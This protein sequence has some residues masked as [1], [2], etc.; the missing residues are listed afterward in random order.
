MQK[1]VCFCEHSFE[2]DIP[3]EYNLETDKNVYLSILNGDFMNIKCPMC[4][5]ILKP[6]FPFKI[7]DK[8]KN[9]DFFFIPENDRTSFLINKLPYEINKPSRIVI[10]YKELVEKLLLFQNDLNDQA[11]E[12]IK[13]YLLIKLNETF[14]S[15]DI[16]I[17]FQKIENDSLFFYIEGLKKDELGQY[18]IKMD[19]YNKILKDIDAKIENPTFATFLEPPYISL[20]KVYVE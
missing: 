16:K 1:I 17:Y 10:G 3:E 9:I 14:K 13:Y 8:T 18:E 19:L 12:I 11:I 2:I 20:N 6:E 4:K 5:T 15:E 7:I